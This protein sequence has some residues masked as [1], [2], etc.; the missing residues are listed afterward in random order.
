ML[1]GTCVS[2]L[3]KW[4]ATELPVAPT[5]VGSKARFFAVTVT[6]GPPPAPPAASPGVTVTVPV[7]VV[8][9]NSQ[10]KKYVPADGAVNEYVVAPG[11]LTGAPRK[12]IG[13]LAFAPL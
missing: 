3:T 7:M 2:S 5:C 12:K 6:A 1:C 10:W 8:G 4:M 13:E 11:P 9:W